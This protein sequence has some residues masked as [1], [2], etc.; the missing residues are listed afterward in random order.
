MDF[1]IYSNKEL[2]LGDVVVKVGDL[3]RRLHDANLLDLSEICAGTFC[4]QTQTA[5]KKFQRQRGLHVSGICDNA[6]WLTLVEASFALGDRLIYLTSPLQQGDDVASLQYLLSL[7]GFDCGRVDG[8]FGQV[9][10]RGLG[11]FQRNYGLVA[12]GICGPLTRQALNRAV[13]HSGS[14]PGFGVVKQRHTATSYNGNLSE[15]RVVLGQFGSIDILTKELF[16]RLRAQDTEVAVIIDGD[17][18]RLDRSHDALQVADPLRRTLA[19]P[20]QRAAAESVD[21]PQTD[22]SEDE[23]RDPDAD[24]LQQ[25][26]LLAQTGQFKD[27]RS[28]VEDGIDAGELIE[29]RHQERD[30][31]RRPHA[32]APEA[33]RRARFFTGSGHGI[34]AGFQFGIGC[35]GRDEFQH[36][37][38]ARTVTFA[39]QQPARAFRNDEAGKRVEQGWQRHDAKHP[40][41]RVVTHAGQQ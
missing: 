31:Y 23:V 26:G 15:F 9:T 36:L 16:D 18:H 4:E 5:V 33:L 7:A 10:A 12:D 24:G 17:A 2:V 6:T 37:H 28:E 30:E 13:R 32:A 38:A 20:E 39:R 11:D 34:R 14:G 41:P 1:G 29:E 3:Q 21:K 40:A 25:R 27:A 22:E 35:M 8:F 19:A